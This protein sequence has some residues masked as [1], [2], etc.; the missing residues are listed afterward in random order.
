MASPRGAACTLKIRPHDD[1]VRNNV[2][3]V[4]APLAGWAT[5]CRALE[6][7]TG[8]RPQSSSASRFTA[9]AAASGTNNSGGAAERA[10]TSTGFPT[11]F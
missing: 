5:S 10:R 4:I 11:G 6:Q 9:G 3:I 2:I 8:H 1:A 7:Q